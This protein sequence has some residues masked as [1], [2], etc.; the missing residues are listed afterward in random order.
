[1]IDALCRLEGLDKRGRVATAGDPYHNQPVK[2]MCE[3]TTLYN[4]FKC[5]KVY[6]GG[7]NDYEGALREN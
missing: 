1:M 6:L 4:C 2:Y 3:Q 7:M 5:G